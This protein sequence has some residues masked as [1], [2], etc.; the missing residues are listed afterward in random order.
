MCCFLVLSDLRVS[1]IAM[2]LFLSF[3][4]KSIIAFNI[5]KEKRLKNLQILKKQKKF[6]MFSYRKS[7][8]LLNKF[9]Y[10]NL[11]SSVHLCVIFFLKLKSF[12]LWFS[13][14][15]FC[16]CLGLIVNYCFSFSNCLF[17]WMNSFRDG[18]KTRSSSQPQANFS[19]VEIGNQNWLLPFLIARYTQSRSNTSDS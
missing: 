7:A 10:F 9:A 16:F 2:C 11:P 5:F 3:H 12:L 13:V 15:W 6:F 17:S 8:L 14:I 19:L 4:P 18:T 1:L